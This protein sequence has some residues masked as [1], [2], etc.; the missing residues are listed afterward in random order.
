[1]AWPAETA[2]PDFLGSSDPKRISTS[3]DLAGRWSF[4]MCFPSWELAHTLSAAE[5]LSMAAIAANI[6]AVSD[7]AIKGVLTVCKAVG[8]SMSKN[9]SAR[10]QITLV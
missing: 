4:A 7:L 1:L 5:L 2:R 6:P 8:Q 3:S 9:T 10:L